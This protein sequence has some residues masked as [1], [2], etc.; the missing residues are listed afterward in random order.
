MTRACLDDRNRMVEQ[1]AEQFLGLLQETFLGVP[2]DGSIPSEACTDTSNDGARL[3]CLWSRSRTPNHNSLSY[4]KTTR[5]AALR[6]VRHP[7]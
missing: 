4:V 7:L 6:T 5:S 2:F 3:A 1:N